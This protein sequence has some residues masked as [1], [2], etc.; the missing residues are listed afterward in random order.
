M[1][2]PNP[3]QNSPQWGAT[4]KLVVGLTL[5]AIVAALLIRFQSLIAPLLLA[6]VL[7][8]L[9]HPIVKWLQE[10]T[11]VSWRTAANIIFI[12]LVLLLLGSFTLTGFA[13]FGQLES[14][15][16]VVQRFFNDLPELLEQLTSQVY[17][18]GP[19]EFSLSQF[20][21]ARD[22]DS[23]TQQILG[24]VQPLLGQ[25]GSLIST[26]AGQTLNVF[27]QMF[28]VLLVSYFLLADMGRIPDKL[29]DIELPGYDADIR[30]LGRALAY[31]WN[32]FLR[33]QVILFTLTV[34]VYS[35]L[36]GVLGLRYAIGLAL[37]AGLARFVPYVGPFLTWTV[38]ALVA[39]F[40]K[41]NYLGLEPWQ[42]VILV[43]LLAIIVDWFFDNMLSP[44]ILGRSLGL[45]PAAVLVAAIIALNLLGLVGVVLAAPVLASLTLI[46]RYTMRKM[47]DQNPWPL[48][49]DE[50]LQTERF[51]ARWRRRY[52]LIKDWW[53][54]RFKAKSDQQE[55][56]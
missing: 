21:S 44:R 9:L 56:S 18:L 15:V 10:V 47:L 31:L 4:I 5:V 2:D 52:G 33:G 36:M 35:I 12:I 11:P 40:Q 29:V 25:A 24:V 19:Y 55:K 50:H 39:F 46:G 32:A 23:L 28:F 42:Y 1:D 14:L 30:R 26:V 20:F 43:L 48:L 6:F 16:S 41:S 7:T 45:H 3:V 22:V 13:V 17:T 38:T 53:Q 49:E 34:M 37:L 8:Y 51:W 27:G 54:A